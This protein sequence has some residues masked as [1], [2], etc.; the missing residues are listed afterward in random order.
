MKY[1]CSKLIYGHRAFPAVSVAR[2]IFSIVVLIVLFTITKVSAAYSTELSD[3][4]GIWRNNTNF[5]DIVEFH[6]NGDVFNSRFGQGRISSTYENGANFAVVY[7]SGRCFYYI[8]VGQ[9]G[10]LMIVD[11]SKLSSSLQC[12]SGKYTKVAVSLGSRGSSP[13]F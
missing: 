8:Y 5:E 10:F 3:I 12:L 2:S 1:D 11:R 4:V 13:F 9:D 7:S 6:A